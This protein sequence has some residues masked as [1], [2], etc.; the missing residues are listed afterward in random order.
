M[1][2]AGVAVTKDSVCEVRSVISLLPSFWSGKRLNLY[3]DGD[4][5]SGFEETNGMLECCA[6]KEN[7]VSKNGKGYY[8]YNI[9]TNESSD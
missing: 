6:K 5:P 7:I 3:S 1:D 4:R 9:T 2:C 8:L